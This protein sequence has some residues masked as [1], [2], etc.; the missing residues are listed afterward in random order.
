MPPVADQRLSDAEL[1]KPLKADG[2][3]PPLMV[4]TLDQAGLHQVTVAPV[5]ALRSPTT[6]APRASPAN[7]VVD[8]VD[9]AARKKL[10][11]AN[12]AATLVGPVTWDT[13][14]EQVATPDVFVRPAQV[15]ADVPDPRARWTSL[16]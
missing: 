16:P 10:S 5:V 3:A 11:P 12:D 13:V 1:A 2:A 14:T 4:L 8:V 7:T 9:D 6:N 15:C